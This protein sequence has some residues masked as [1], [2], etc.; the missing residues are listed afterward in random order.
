MPGPARFRG[1]ALKFNVATDK[2]REHVLDDRVR[3]LLAF[4]RRW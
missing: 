4:V 1:D 2:V 3:A